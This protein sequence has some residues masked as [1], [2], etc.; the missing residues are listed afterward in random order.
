MRDLKAMVMVDLKRVFR[1]ST[2]LVAMMLMM[3]TSRLLE[4]G[5]DGILS[6]SFY[7]LLT[8]MIAFYADIG[9]DGEG[10]TALL[11][12]SLPL[13][14]RMVMISHHLVTSILL[15][16]FQV[17]A[18]VMLVIGSAMG[19]GVDADWPA[20][21]AGYIGI[22]LSIFSIMIPAYIGCRTFPGKSVF[23]RLMVIGALGLLGFRAGVSLLFQATRS[24][25]FGTWFSDAMPWL[26]LLVGLTA[27]G[28]SLFVS[29]RNYE[30]QDH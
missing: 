9:R 7:V 17:M 16:V 28:V 20:I 19:M 15:V 11:L 6:Y 30:R 22:I 21:A 18:S 24:Q 13:P 2:V 3:I 14:R 10:K 8:A 5:E 29:I 25:S 12:D 23:S 26:L 1:I 4:G 27:W